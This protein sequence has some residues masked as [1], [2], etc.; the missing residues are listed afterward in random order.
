MGVE[1]DDTVRLRVPRQGTRRRR[2]PWIAGAAAGACLSVGGAWWALRPI[3]PPLV[4][5]ASEPAAA[6]NAPAPA[7][8]Q[9]AAPQP[10]ETQPP[11]SALA[12]ADASKPAYD[13]LNSA[14]RTQ[15]AFAPPATPAPPAA[16]APMLAS[17]A[18]ILSDSPDQLAVYRFAA[19]PA[20][21]VLQFPTLA[22]QGLM[23]NRVA[24][25]VEKGGY[26]HE[27]VLPRAE[28]NA[29]IIAGGATPDDFYYGHDYRSADLLR[30][31]SLA[32]DLNAQE[33]TL[34]TL[35]HKLGWDEK[36]S[37]GALVTLVRQSKGNAGLDPSARAAILRHELSHGVYFTNPQYAGYSAQFWRDRLTQDERDKFVAFLKR[38]GYDTALPDLMI[39][40]TQA[41][42]MHTPDRRYFNPADVGL[43]EQ[44]VAELRQI[45]LVGMPPSWLRDRTTADKLP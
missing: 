11:P 8:S 28:L 7:Q 22:E 42:L 4:A 40:E 17:E 15:L 36:G 2:A 9:T 14:P 13:Q 41:Y 39:N 32:K 5:A 12:A 16:Y 6:T 29:R 26:P 37:V 21:I 24:A 38:E 33:Q 45:F 43:S 27:E 25:L 20:V 3:A 35:V 23:L 30:F 18:D 34:L 1:S 10:S 44:R 19:Q 31:F